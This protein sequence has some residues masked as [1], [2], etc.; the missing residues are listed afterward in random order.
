MQEKKYLFTIPMKVRDYECDI[1]GVVNNANYQRYM[2]HCRH[3]FLESLGENFA[4]MHEDGLDAF[5]RKVTITYRQPL[6]SGEYFSA[7]LNC[8]REGAKMVFEQY[9]IRQ[10]GAIMA[11][12]IVEAV[13]VKDG[14][15]TRGEFFDG[16]T[17]TIAH[18]QQPTV[19]L[20]H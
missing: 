4:A 2:E 18:Y 19:N 20:L 3:E 6:R 10:D 17:E 13:A 1:Q 11:E 8:R 16:L 14:R 7:A 15:L 12:G 9:I 5:V